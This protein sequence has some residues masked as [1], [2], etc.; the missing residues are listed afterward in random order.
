MS[1]SIHTFQKETCG[2][3]TC[4][5]KAF[6]ADGQVNT[7][8]N[9][10]KGKTSKSC[11]FVTPTTF[12]NHYTSTGTIQPAGLN[13]NFY[14]NLSHPSSND[15]LV[16][17]AD[18]TKAALF[19][20]TSLLITD[21]DD[22]VKE[23]ISE[24]LLISVERP[25]A[26]TSLP[27]RITDTFKPTLSDG[28]FGSFDHI[29]TTFFSKSPHQ[30]NVLTN[31]NELALGSPNLVQI[32][33]PDGIDWK[34]TFISPSEHPDPA[35]PAYTADDEYAV[36][37]TYSSDGTVYSQYV[38]SNG[39]PFT[40]P[41]LRTARNCQTFAVFEKPTGFITDRQPFD[42]TPSVSPNI[43]NG[44]SGMTGGLNITS[45]EACIYCINIDNRVININNKCL[46]I[47]LELTD[48]LTGQYG[49]TTN[50]V[51][52][53]ALLNAAFSKYNMVGWMAIIDLY[54]PY[55]RIVYPDN[56]LKFSIKLKKFFYEG[57]VRND[58][59]TEIQTYSQGALTEYVK[60]NAVGVPVT[61]TNLADI[62]NGTSWS[63][64]TDKNGCFL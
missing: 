16:S 23:H 15:L 34:L 14:T 6:I 20:G 51:N 60:T 2:D 52:L 63:A 5:P 17:P 36:M 28:M 11:I 3:C 1:R 54:Y 29:L 56:V 55:F 26:G 22:N 40:N 64:V 13:G 31:P 4:G 10:Y 50:G 44:I 48:G 18:L 45:G 9:V 39:E 53:V 21:H 61:T 25:G 41:V 30:F 37:Y 24:P 38:Y 12:T 49:N 19:L 46:C 7:T 42:M 27:N 58:C 32:V 43:C 47:P 35:D 57:T 62:L 59:Y 33:W 8:I